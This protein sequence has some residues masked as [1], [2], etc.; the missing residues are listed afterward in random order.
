M[1]GET[2]V[3][4]VLDQHDVAAGDVDVEV[5]D[6]ADPAG[7][8]RVAGDG[9]EVDLRDDRELADQVGEEGTLPLST[10]TR[11]TPSS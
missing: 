7:A 3:D 9:E 8:R 5:L 1:S 11:T 2:G 10:A 4:D 6:D